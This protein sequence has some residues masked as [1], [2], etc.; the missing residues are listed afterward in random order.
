MNITIRTLQQK[1]KKTTGKTP[2]AYQREIILHQAKIL[3]KSGDIKTVSELTYQLGFE[4]SHYFSKLYKKQFG[5]SP[6]EELNL[7]K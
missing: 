5:L 6:K 4:D 2:K 3:L 7:L 1:V